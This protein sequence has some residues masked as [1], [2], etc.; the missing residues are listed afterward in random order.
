MSRRNYDEDQAS[1]E[2][3]QRE[4]AVDEIRGDGMDEFLRDLWKKMLRA[5]EKG[6]DFDLTFEEIVEAWGYAAKSRATAYL[7]MLVEA[8]YVISKERGTIT[9]YRALPAEEVEGEH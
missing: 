9:K 2:A 7:P 4:M 5:Q 3:L 6:N 1:I 8:G